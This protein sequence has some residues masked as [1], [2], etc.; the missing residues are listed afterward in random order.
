[1]SK[2]IIQAL[3]KISAAIPADVLSTVSGEIALIER[4]SISIT[5]KLSDNMA[6]IMKK[7]GKIKDLSLELETSQE[8]L[9]EVE[10]TIETLK[11]DNSNEELKAKLETLQ[12]YKDKID[13]QNRQ[14]FNEQFTTFKDH[15]DFEKVAKKLV[16]LPELDESGK[17]DFSQMSIEDIDINMTK[18]NEAK[19]YGLFADGGDSK[20]SPNFRQKPIE[21]DTTFE[22]FPPGK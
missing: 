22:G 10:A 14:A 11:A 3:K 15:A 19:D 5:G 7:K 16:N 18:F 1:M 12:G 6:E 2:E 8:K 20:A 17:I 9:S 13:E 4:E 21:K